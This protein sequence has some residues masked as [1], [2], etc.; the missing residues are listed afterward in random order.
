MKT[1]DMFSV[2]G[3]VTVIVGGK[4]YYGD[5][6]TRTFAEAGAHVYICARNIES[7]E[8]NAIGLRAE[9]F[10]VTA[11]RAD[12]SNEQDVLAFRDF[13]LERVGRVD[14]L[15]MNAVARTCHGFD[16]P[17]SEFEE[18]MR[19]NATGTFA[20]ARAFG[21]VMKEQ[22]IGSIIMVGSIQGM[23]GP[24][25]DLYAGLGMDGYYAPDYFFHKGGMINLCRFLAS[26]YG[27]HGVR[28]NVVSPGGCHE[29]GKETA[30]SERYGK[31]TFLGRMAY[32]EDLVGTILFLASDAS[33]YVTGVNI[34]VD[35]GYTA[36]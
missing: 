3:R 12:Q 29:H 30:F 24:D 22:G 17:I 19:I 5:C 18:S 1:L 35:A 25:A 15:V 27:P 16:R 23:I 21:N 10:D 11:F 33:A 14:I 36:K 9:G 28:V 32:A 31:R 8:N 20:V 4:G 7:L 6:L 2:D 26:Y 34:P 13:V